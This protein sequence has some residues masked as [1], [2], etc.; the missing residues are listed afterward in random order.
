MYQPFSKPDAY[1][2][3]CGDLRF[4]VVERRIP[5]APR[6][7]RGVRGLFVTDVH[8]S[9]RTTR[10]HL[11]AFAARI[12]ALE[13]DILFWGGDYSDDAGHAARLFG[14]LGSLRPPLGSFGVLGNNDREAWADI[15]ELRAAM[16]GAGI[17]LLV[18]ESC[19]VPVG[20]GRLI[21]AGIDDYRYGRPSEEGLYPA[22]RPEGACRV[23]LSH[24]PVLP[25][26][27]P[28]L[29]LSGHTHG[30][31]FNFLGVTPYTVGFERLISR[32]SPSD[33][34]AGLHEHGGAQILVSKGIG[35]SRIPLRIG[36]RPETELLCF[37]QA[38]S[39][40]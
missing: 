40:M 1:A 8:V 26:R 9:R 32:E 30:G 21:V 38:V 12:A 15:G 23:L 2:A 13:P 16:A 35:A 18:N 29:M 14:H 7:L 24:F 6:F 22:A 39:A 31:Q 5:G 19:E 36:V 10:A 3:L 28:E 34:I 25:E 17:R 33:Y 11:E 37:G 20:G 4:R 27:L